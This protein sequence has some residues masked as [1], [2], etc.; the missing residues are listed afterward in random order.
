[1]I[2]SYN[3]ISSPKENSR[4]NNIVPRKLNTNVHKKFLLWPTDKYITNKKV[5]I[6]KD[7]D[8]GRIIQD[9]YKSS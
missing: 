8:H 1:M 5:F 6:I 7:L 9:L 2:L 4:L 3:I